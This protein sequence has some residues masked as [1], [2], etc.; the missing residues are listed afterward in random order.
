MCNSQKRGMDPN[1]W[2]FA[3]FDGALEAGNAIVLPNYV[4]NI[5]EDR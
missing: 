4:C 3:L 5:M 2:R 1:K